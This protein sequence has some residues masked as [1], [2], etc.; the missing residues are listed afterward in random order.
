MLSTVWI[1]QR[2]SQ[3]SIE[4]RRG[5]KEIEVIRRRKGGI[6]M[7]E[8]EREIQPVISSVSVLHSPEHTQRF[9]GLHGEEKWKGGDRGDLE[10]KRR[11]KGERAIR[12]VISLPSKNGY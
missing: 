1:P 3:S 12:P 9:M 11:V 7:R 10:E 4:K 2:C 8:R 6:K 5:R